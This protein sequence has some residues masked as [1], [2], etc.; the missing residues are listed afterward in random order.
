MRT[1]C[2]AC[3]L[4]GL[5]AMFLAATVAH[6]DFRILCGDK[7]ERGVEHADVAFLNEL[8]DMKVY[9]GGKELAQNAFGIKGL[10]G[11]RWM[12]GIVLPGN[13]NRQFIFTH[14]DTS[15]QEYLVDERGRS[16]KI[17]AKLKC[18]WQAPEVD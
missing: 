8:V 10:E 4:T 14:A 11:D 3:L 2:Q 13:A 7:R 1:M 9:V 12:V 5:M 6:A 18:V 16:K 15:A 17:G